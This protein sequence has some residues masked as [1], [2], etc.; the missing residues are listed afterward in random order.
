MATSFSLSLLLS[1]HLVTVKLTHDNFLLWKAQITAYFYGQNLLGFLDG[2]TL[3][4]PSLYATEKPTFDFI[5]WHQ[6]DQA[7]MSVLLSS[8]F[9]TL[10]AHVL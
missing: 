8:F 7:I 10:I 9:D 4:A 6:Q 3:T 5:A 2:T 1:S